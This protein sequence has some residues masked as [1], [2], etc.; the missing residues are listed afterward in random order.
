MKNEIRPSLVS[1]KNDIKKVSKAEI[2][3]YLIK[4]IDNID[5]ILEN[6]FL[7]SSCITLFEEIKENLKNNN[8]QKFYYKIGEKSKSVRYT[9][10]SNLFNTINNIISQLHEVYIDRNSVKKLYIL[11]PYCVLISMLINGSC[12]MGKYMI[13]YN[14]AYKSISKLKTEKEITNNY[15]KIIENH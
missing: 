3:E 12:F 2:Y 9:E 14:F 11:H 6:K 7:I 10:R 5:L 15:F 13:K 1:K 4:I 8:F